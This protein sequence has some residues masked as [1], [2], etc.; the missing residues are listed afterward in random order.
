MVGENISH[1]RITAEIGKGGMGVV[2]QAEDTQLGRTVA[3]KFLPPHLTSD[4]DAKSRFITEARTASALDHPALCTIHEI[5][6]TDDGQLFIA[7]GY[8]EGETL[9]ERLQRETL[10]VKS[11]LDIVRRLAEGLAEAH[12]RDIVHRDVKPANIFLC[13]NGQV[14]LLDFGVAKLVGGTGL[15][16]AGQIIGTAAYMSPEQATGDPIDHRVDIWALGVVLREMITGRSPFEAEFVQ[17][18]MYLIMQQ[19][20]EPLAGD[21]K[22]VT[23]E[24]D[25]VMARML[26][27][28]ADERYQ[29]LEHFL[30]DLDAVLEG[31]VPA[32]SG[33]GLRLSL[34]KS[35][36]VTAILLAL[37]GAAWMVFG[38]DDSP[39]TS[40]KSVAV[41]PCVDREETAE[42]SWF[43][44][45]VTDDLIMKLAGLG[46]LRVINP[47]SVQEYKDTDK[48]LAR[49][50][51]ELH[52]DLLLRSTVAQNGD[53]LRFSAQLIAPKTGEI[54][55]ANNY[56]QG[57]RDIS[58]LWGTVAAEIAAA[59][60][61][62]LT[63]EETSRVARTRPVDPQ[64][65]RAYQQG[66]QAWKLSSKKSLLTA[67]E[68][69]EAAVAIDPDFALGF[70]GLA[71]AHASFGQP[72]VHM[73]TGTYA[74][75]LTIYDRH[76]ELA[77]EAVEQA[78]KIDP[79]LPEAHA[80]RGFLLRW[81]DPVQAEREFEIA[82]AAKPSIASAHYY[83][84][85]LLSAHGRLDEA[86]EHSDMAISLEPTVIRFKFSK[87]GQIEK[88][89][90][91]VEAEKFLESLTS[92][93][94]SIQ[95][96]I[97]SNRAWILLTLKR[98]DEARACL[99]GYAELRGISP[100]PALISVDYV[101]G[102][103]TREEF[104]PVAEH[105]ARY[106]GP[107][108]AAGF[109]AAGGDFDSAIK[110]LEMSYAMGDFILVQLIAQGFPLLRPLYGDARF[111]DLLD[112]FGLPPPAELPS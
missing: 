66:R 59:T 26:A 69:F 51:E 49:I 103:I 82:L 104:A 52:V 54:V 97:L 102:K 30:A 111:L 24:L 29:R 28:K 10:D 80:T 73:G 96:S 98:Y 56:E 20:P 22:D 12:S 50:A 53:S 13:A 2:Y 99:K 109:F 78:L 72:A 4:P 48:P 19:V 5:G 92:S 45:G 76:M 58:R 27:K 90:G 79:N 41:L 63:L 44:E 47:M 64:A 16:Q 34:R 70:T 23:P 107:A 85:G 67:I 18:S 83:F 112:R 65:Y 6:E 74:D 94:P 39:P 33:K 3:L 108:Y 46:S 75:L 110:Y 106:F 25:R 81:T 77:G 89:Y 62:D 8:Y 42:T 95:G 43:S 86:W 61:T 91:L 100:D 17:S 93:S 105:I 101:E 31:G 9:K 11:A 21:Y 88:Q 36:T 35:V 60:K 14:K 71:D 84:W 32:G 55:W 57:I 15:T 37:G 1:F 40:V 38:P 7:M 87:T 68:E